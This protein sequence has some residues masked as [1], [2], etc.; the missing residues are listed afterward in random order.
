M[1][2]EGQCSLAAPDHCVQP[3][4][5]PATE[6][7]LCIAKSKS[8]GDAIG[9]HGSERLVCSKIELA[10]CLLHMC[11]LHLAT[12]KFIGRSDA[13]ELACHSKLHVFKAWFS[14]VSLV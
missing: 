4:A 13:N 10:H 11:S 12:T 7:V 6:R 2:S 9:G 5:P 14:L 8:N 1:L 3:D